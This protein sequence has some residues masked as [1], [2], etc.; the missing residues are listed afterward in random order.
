LIEEI[1]AEVKARLTAVEEQ[2]DRLQAANAVHERKAVVARL[3]REYKLPD[4][5]EADGASKVLVSEQ[6]VQSLLAAPNENPVRSLVE[7]RASLLA[8]ARRSDPMTGSRPTSREQYPR[9][10][11]RPHDAKSFVRAIS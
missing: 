5:Y 1:E 10:V 9:D 11:D 6:F 8:A 7:E 4:P 3:L 2:L